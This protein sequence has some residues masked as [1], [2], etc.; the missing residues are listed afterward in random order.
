MIAN[1]TI[2]GNMH[3]S[4]E[5]IVIANFR[6]DFILRRTTI[7]CT[8]FTYNIAVTH[9]EIGF[10]TLEFQILWHFANRRKLKYFVIASYFGWTLNDDMRPNPSSF[11]NFNIRPN[12]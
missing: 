1:D 9:L 8:K 5:K 11:T 7:K 12:H 6:H 10:L 3:I 2:M 4:H